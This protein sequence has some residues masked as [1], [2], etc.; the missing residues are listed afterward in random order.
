MHTSRSPFTSLLRRESTSDSSACATN[1]SRLSVPV[2]ARLPAWTVPFFACLLT[3]TA[4][5][6]AFAT[7]LTDFCFC[8]WSKPL[9]P[10]TFSFLESHPPFSV[11]AAGPME[12]FLGVSSL[13]MVAVREV[14]VM[15]GML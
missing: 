2:E 3:T 8:C 12:L 10:V 15:A 9:V 14:I 11:R 6:V 5:E 1:I 7:A 13:S 4:P